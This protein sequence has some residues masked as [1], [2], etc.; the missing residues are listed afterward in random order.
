MFKKS[1]LLIPF[2]LLA[3]P[4]KIDEILTPKNQFKLNL[5]I[6]YT[7]IQK[8]SGTIA[9]ITYQTA[10]GDFV[11]IPTYI[12]SENSNQDYINYSIGI[13]YGLN[14]KTEIYSNLN[15]F[16]NSTHI[17][18]ETSYSNKFKRGFNNFNIGLTY[19]IKKETDT[20]S[21][22]IDINI[23]AIERVRFTSKYK[24]MYF[25]NYTLNITSYYT[26]DPIVF[27]INASYRINK[28]TYYK[29]ESIDNGNQ[30]IIS[31]QIYFA[32]NPFTSIN[33]GIKYEY[34]SKD[35]I[36]DKIVSNNGSEI[37]YLLGVSYE[38]NFKNTINFNYEKKD[39]STYTSSTIN[40]NLTHKY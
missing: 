15:Y 20:P 33:W 30:I 11:N 3:K 16:M 21:L 37:S 34:H 22:L 7:N 39:T 14:N 32:V 2:L 40:L 29:N 36:D 17:N 35:K 31:P 18:G 8:K 6:S 1:I 25:K 26:V 10:N 23:D 4:V 5:N 24:N 19:K 27:L 28:K 12:E 13:R 9:L 38:I